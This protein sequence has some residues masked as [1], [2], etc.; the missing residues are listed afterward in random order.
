MYTRAKLFALSSLSLVNTP[1]PSPL[2]F[3][4]LLDVSPGSPSCHAPSIV[5]GGHGDHLPVQAGDRLTAAGADGQL[6]LRSPEPLTA[7][8]SRV[9]SVAGR[10]SWT[11]GTRR[12]MER[13]ESGVQLVR[14]GP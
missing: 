6:I 3:P 11:A 10:W 7:A 2:G 1:A 8:P 9:L 12:A 14:K 13:A 4:R 5:G